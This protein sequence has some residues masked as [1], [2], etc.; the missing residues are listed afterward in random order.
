[1]IFSELKKS[2][3]P[4]V[5]SEDDGM[6]RTALA[7]IISNRLNLGDPIWVVLIGASSSGKSQVLRPLALT[8]EKYIHR[9]D[10]LTEN[11][12]LSGINTG[13]GKEDVSLLKRIGKSGILVVSDLTVIFSKSSE[14]RNAILGQLRM[15]YDGEMTKYSGTKSEPIRWEGS[16]GML[17]G[18]TPSIYGHFEEVADM[19]ER[20]IYYRMKEYDIEKA[21]RISLNRNVFGKD[22]DSKLAEMYSEY[23][24]EA[25]LSA[26]ET[27]IV[28][29]EDIK[30]KI[31]Q[32]SMF[33]SNLRTPTSYDK[34]QKAIDRIPVPEMPM[35]VA[36]QL[37]GLARGLIAMKLHDKGTK[38]LDESDMAIIEWCAYSL[39][40]EEKRACLRTLAQSTESLTTA[41]VAEKIGLSTEIART[42]LQ[43]LSA[44]GIVTRSGISGSLT[45]EISDHKTLER[46]RR[47][48]NIVIE[49]F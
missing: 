21:T 41:I 44:I 4:Y 25:T 20:F 8:D 11:T 7:S 32:I 24:T 42:S 14:T 3:E 27:E 39:A 36:L 45:W 2:I 40:N 34:Y 37:M 28:V 30:E 17:A 49:E 23:I 9:V 10:D 18:S 48:E 6:L 16:L 13:E 15:V 47:V 22:L 19:G 26:K 43:H 38:D 12:L 1:M 31:V 35:R 46:V 33:A 5:Y 29:P